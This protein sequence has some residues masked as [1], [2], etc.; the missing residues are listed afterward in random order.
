MIFHRNLPPSKYIFVFTWEWERRG[1]A[2]R[3]L[4]MQIV[5]AGDSELRYHFQRFAPRRKV[6]SKSRNIPPR[7]IMTCWVF[8]FLIPSWWKFSRIHPLRSKISANILR[9][10]LNIKKQFPG[11]FL[12]KNICHVTLYFRNS[13][14]D[15]SYSSETND[16]SAL[17][18][19]SVDD[20]ILEWKIFYF[21]LNFFLKR[22]K[23]IFSLIFQFKR[24][25]C[26]S[27]YWRWRRLAVWLI[28][29]FSEIK[30]TMNLFFLFISKDQC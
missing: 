7:W 5:T 29:K 25:L 23:F 2:G 28:S 27:C 1:G 16:S 18:D 30:I 3:D 6:L 20:F 26:C 13:E 14:F 4:S 19:F 8:P 21:I 17:K 9:K 11:A 15:L 22:F 12:Q 10:R 24:K